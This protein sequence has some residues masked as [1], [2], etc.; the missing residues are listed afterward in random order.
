[1]EVL[2]R[3]CIETGDWRSTTLWMLTVDHQW[4]HKFFDKKK[5][6]AER[7]S[8]TGAWDCGGV[9]VLHTNGS[10]NDP[11][12][13]YLLRPSTT[14]IFCTNL[15]CNLKARVEGVCILL[16]LQTDTRATGERCR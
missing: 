16:G 15:P 7:G 12:R 9:L 11:G 3:P 5:T 4:E 2:G 14:E 8:I 13:L 6:N 10:Y 1:M